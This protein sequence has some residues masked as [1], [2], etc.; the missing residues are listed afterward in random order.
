MD[1]TPLYTG[2]PILTFGINNLF[3]FIFVF[4]ITLFE[5]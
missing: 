2:I 3:S 4:I 5:F 1:S